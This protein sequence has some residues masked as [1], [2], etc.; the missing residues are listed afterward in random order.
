MVALRLNE[1]SFNEIL[2]PI[3][4]IRSIEV[5]EDWFTRTTGT[6][7][8]DWFVVSTAKSKELSREVK[9]RIVTADINTG[10]QTYF[11]ILYECKVAGGINK[12]YDRYKSIVECARSIF[13]EIE[14]MK[15]P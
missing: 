4:K 11:L 10:I 15:N 13:D 12:S 6:A 5:I 2:V 9:L 8:G 1:D 7:M 14:F 3:D